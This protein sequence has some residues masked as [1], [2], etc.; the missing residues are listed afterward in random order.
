MLAFC[1]PKTEGM[2]I[3]ECFR[4]WGSGSRARL[5]FHE[6]AKGSKRAMIYQAFVF[7][8]VVRMHLQAKLHFNAPKV[9]NSLQVARF[10]LFELFHAGALR[11]PRI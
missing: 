4:V 8:A 10:K 9:L 3:T 5:A 6:A 2:A 11:E 1:L 7:R